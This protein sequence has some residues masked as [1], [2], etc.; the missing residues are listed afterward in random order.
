MPDDTSIGLSFEEVGIADALARWSLVV[1][2]NQR[3]YEWTD[4]VDKLLN[5]LFLSF[6]RGESIYFLGAI[7][8][9]SG[10]RGQRQIA[11][12]QQR[13][14]TVSALLAA[15]RD[16]LL[17]LGDGD[18]A[19]AYQSKYLLDYDPRSRTSKPKLTLNYEDRE[20]FLQTVLLPPDQRSNYIGRHFGSH[21]LLAVTM[22]AA[23][24][25]THKISYPYPVGEKAHRIY[26]WLEFLHNSAKIIVIN[27]P[28]RVGNAFKMFETL[29]A[30][31]LPAS[32]VDLV[33]NYLFEKAQ[34][35]MH[36]IHPS[37]ISMKATIEDLGDDELL[38]T[39]IRHFWISQHGP[40]TADELGTKIEESVTQE[41]Q[42][43]LL[44]RG[45]DES[46]VDY[47]AILTAREHPRL[48]IYGN[49][50]REHIF[51]ITRELGIVQ[52]R[53]LLLSIIKRFS[54]EE[55]RKAFKLLLSWSVRFLISGGGGG[56]QLD[57]YYGLRA[58]EIH[59]RQITTA[60]S[61]RETMQTVVPNNEVFGRAFTNASVRRSQI[62][63]Y[64]LR[65]IEILLEGE[66][67][68]EMVPSQDVNVL[69]LEHI[70]PVTPSAGWN[71]NEE[72]AAANYKRL[73]NMT[74]LHAGDNIGAANRPFAEKK[75]VYAGSPLE[76]TKE[77]S[78]YD[79]WGPAEIERRQARL[80]ELALRVWPIT[81]E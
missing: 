45:L 1:P 39:Y 9:T 20:Y 61:L 44:V 71:I 24:D 33:K 49:D 64:Y 31:G 76:I 30:R 72:V 46:S 59:N 47:A 32:Q 19:A 36:D 62:A 58:M 10:D 48:E 40:T 63:R 26:D 17:E 12:G 52:I 56:G 57:R 34:D 14:A 79:D 29:N 68:P 21:D 41:A 69:N 70:L 13:L 3:A 66:N 7:V 50:A 43:L 77:L 11:D 35:R 28:R 23:I 38:L 81:L 15:A 18:G 78:G 4:E 16:H 6:E 73:G 27:V 53:P 54:V 5:D 22:E 42:A 55:G 67:N 51:A 80:A 37:W 2:L 25:R 75:P 65:A 74:L 60:R 8:L